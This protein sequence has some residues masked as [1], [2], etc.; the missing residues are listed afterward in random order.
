[1][2]KT[3]TGRKNMDW[4][5]NVD[6]VCQGSG[7]RFLFNLC[8]MYLKTH[9]GVD[10]YGNGDR[11]RKIVKGKEVEITRDEFDSVKDDYGPGWAMCCADCPWRYDCEEVRR[12]VQGPSTHTANADK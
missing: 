11:Y 12:L 2:A 8:D 10:Y 5:A 1:M 9:D 7:R 3:K 6:Y 4:K